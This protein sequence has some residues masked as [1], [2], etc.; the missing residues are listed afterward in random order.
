VNELGRY[1]STTLLERALPIVEQSH[2]VLANNIANANTPGFSPTHVS[3]SETLR[4]AMAG[5]DT[6]V[7]LQVTHPGHLTGSASA[8]GL[9]LER[10]AFEPGRNDESTL[11]IDREMVEL[12]KNNARYNILSAILTKRYQGMREVLRLP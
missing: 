4:N 2:R 5:T 11:D 8:A 12:L 1:D 9:V 3:F 6:G 7:A 10:D